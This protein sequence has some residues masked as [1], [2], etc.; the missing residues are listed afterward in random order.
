MQEFG[1]SNFPPE[2]VAEFISVCEEK[3]Y[4]KPSVYQGLYNLLSRESEETLFPLLRKHN[5]AF[6]AYR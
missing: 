1:L 5:I 4:V 2:L 3:G 6:N